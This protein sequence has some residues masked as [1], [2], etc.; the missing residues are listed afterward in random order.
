M[1][2]TKNGTKYDASINGKYYRFATLREIASGLAWWS[3]QHF[4]IRVE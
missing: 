1:K 2:T 4:L 3:G